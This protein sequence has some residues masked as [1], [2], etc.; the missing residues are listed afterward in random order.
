MIIRM[1]LS[2]TLAL[3]TDA[4]DIAHGECNEECL[5][6]SFDDLLRMWVLLVSHSITPE[7][8]ERGG[9]DIL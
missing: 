7:G 1:R 8:N 4:Q 9:G 6:V 2:D 5:R 3:F